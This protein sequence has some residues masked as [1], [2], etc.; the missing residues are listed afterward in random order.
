MQFASPS[1]LLACLLLE[2]SLRA[3]TEARAAREETHLKWNQS[4]RPVPP[5]APEA[6]G[7]RAA[8]ASP[9]GPSRT[10][11][12]MAAAR[13]LRSL[14][15][16]AAGTPDGLPYAERVAEEGLP[17]SVQAVPGGAPLGIRDVA[18]RR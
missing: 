17:A 3:V 13:G 4:S 9:P 2:V 12:K 18:D 1:V 6:T 11:N 10:R 14:P 16:E 15:R 5:E 7:S 8:V